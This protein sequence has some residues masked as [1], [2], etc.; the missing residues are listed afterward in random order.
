MWQGPWS[1]VAER[2]TSADTAFGGRKAKRGVRVFPPAIPSEGGVALTLPAALQ[3]RG[4]CRALFFSLCVSA[5][6]RLLFCRNSRDF[7]PG[8]K[9]DGFP[10]HMPVRQAAP[11]GLR[12]AETRVLAGEE[13]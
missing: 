3:G 13:D 10:E 1:A 9:R 2:G 12:E 7:D 8:E 11:D 4:S 5:S 6:L